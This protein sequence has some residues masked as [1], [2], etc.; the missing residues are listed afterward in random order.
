MALSKKTVGVIIALIIVSLS[1]L[2]VLQILLLDYAMDL[3]EQAFRRNVLAS[4]GLVA[5]KIATR[6][7]MQMAMT[8]Q[9]WA[10][11]MLAKADSLRTTID[12]A[13]INFDLIQDSNDTTLNKQLVIINGDTVQGQPV[14]VQNGELHYNIETPQRVKI[15]S[16][17]MASGHETTIIDTFSMPGD[18]TIGLDSTGYGRGQYLWQYRTSDVSVVLQMENGI[19][20][21]DII[22]PS[23][24]SIKHTMLMTVFGNLISGEHKPL[25]ERIE[26]DALDSLIKSSLNEYGIDIDYAFA[27]RSYFGD[28]LQLIKGETYDKNLKTT[29]YRA[30]LFPQSLFSKSYELLLYFPGKQMFLWRQTGPMLLLTIV[31]VIIITGCFAYTIRTIIRQKR[32]AGHTVDFINN[33]THEFK[34]PISTVK[35][36]CEAIMRP[37]SLSNP[38]KIARYSEMI[39]NENRR[40]SVQAE[41]ILQ[42][43]VLEEGDY[44][45]KIT[46]VDILQ[47]IRRVVESE[48][49]HVE[50]RGGTITLS[51]EA[52]RHT[53]SAD[54]VHIS[55]I[56]N[57]LLDN[58][59]KYSDDVPTIS[60]ATKNIDK[61]IVI[62]IE[63]RGK[64]IAKSD[65]RFV[66]DK[67]FRVSSGNR[68]DVKGFGLGL[69]YVKLM[70]EAMGGAIVLKSELGKG[71][72]ISLSFPAFSG[73]ES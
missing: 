13:C 31:F 71:T 34:T 12:T 7:F 65:Q 20:M 61:D 2:L 6:E 57:N 69:S 16:Y 11:S 44:D 14:W 67:Y 51:L 37:D 60:V 29:P 48:R 72:R 35:L 24:D 21:H 55:N 66:F 49:L 15:E 53:I 8:N 4:I 28:S 32:F 58:A 1:G 68:H 27:V 43:A 38:D 23:R 54:E 25:E 62:S 45:L 3:K 52:K 33:M 70:T 22:P 5:Q 19:Q 59:N 47:V 26:K 41:K 73:E 18:Y 39:Q 10:D 17:D 9:F 64:G 46:E 63:D 40:M 50:H 42:M 56:I 30:G 36:A